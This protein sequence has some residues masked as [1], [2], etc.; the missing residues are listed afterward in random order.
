MHGVCLDLPELG[1]DPLSRNSDPVL[2]LRAA[3]TW[4][5]ELRTVLWGCVDATAQGSTEVTA[6]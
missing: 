6:A 5:E 2:G 3:A 4:Q 1:A